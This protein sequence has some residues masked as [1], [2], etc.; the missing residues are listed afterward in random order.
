MITVAAVAALA[1]TAA[2]PAF[3]QDEAPGESEE[4]AVSYHLDVATGGLTFG[5]GVGLDCAG[6]AEETE[7]EG[8]TTDETASATG[9]TDVT[10]TADDDDSVSDD[11]AAS[12]DADDDSVSDDDAASA[13][14]DDD[15]SAKEHVEMILIG[16]CNTI[17]VLGPNGQLNHGSVMSAVVHAIKAS[18]YDGPRGHLVREFARSD[19]G[20][21]DKLDD[22][23]AGTDGESDGSGK[24]SKDKSDKPGKGKN[25]KGNNGKA[26][27]KKS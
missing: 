10:T 16:E 21:K 12:A 5:Y 23:A 7:D 4:A 11:D 25:N 27:G 1:L 19:L 20:K 13:D 9:D 8:A 15:R 14:A 18:D 22:Q 26:K 2:M 24:A 3:A 17:S 6:L